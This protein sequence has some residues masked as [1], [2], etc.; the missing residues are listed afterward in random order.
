M[1]LWISSGIMLNYTN[2]Y[3]AISG[4]ALHPRRRLSIFK[5]YSHL[6][7][8]KLR[9]ITTHSAC[10]WCFVLLHLPLHAY[11]TGPILRILLIHSY[12]NSRCSYLISCY[13]NSIP[14]LCTPLRTDIILR[15]HSY[16]QPLISH[17]SGR[18][19]ACPVGLRWL[20]FK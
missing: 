11:W 18:N 10:Q 8:R 16:H 14:R 1:K 6:P 4:H 9:M 5:S 7:R 20:R 3:R 17:S 15:C 13:R 19:R 12:L 2:C